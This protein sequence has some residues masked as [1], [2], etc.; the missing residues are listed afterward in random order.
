MKRFDEDILYKRVNSI[1]VIEISGWKKL[2]CYI[3]IE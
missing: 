2:I 1:N 3:Q